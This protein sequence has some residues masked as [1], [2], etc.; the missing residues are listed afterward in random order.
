MAFFRLLFLP[1]LLLVAACGSSSSTAT[2][3]SSITRCSVTVDG[4]GSLP[5]QGGTATLAVTAARECSWSA[6]AEGTWL[7]IRSGASGQGNGS[8]EV[9]AGVNPDPVVRRGAVLLNEERVELTQAAGE[10]AITLAEGGVSFPSS[11]GAGRVEVRASSALCAWRAESN[12]SWI[13]IRSSGSGRGPGEVTFEVAPTTGGPRS[14]EIVVEGQRFAVTQADGCAYTIAPSSASVAA[15]GGGGSVTV[16]TAAGCPWTAAANVSWLSLSTREG[17][18][19]GQVTFGVD[20]TAG[21]RTGTAVIAGRT[22]TVS[23]SGAVPAPSPNPGPAP[24][25]QY[26]VE[27]RSHTVAAA[28]AAISVTV[29]TTPGCA[30]TA[31]SPASWVTL[32]SAATS[33]G[34]GTARFA[35]AATSG[36][37][38]TATVTVAGQSVTVSQ[39]QGC[40]YGISPEEASVPASGGTGRV[41]VAAGSGCSWSASSQA[42][43]LEVTSGGSG[44]GNGEVSFEAAA[45]TGEAR[46]GTLTIAGRTFTVSQEG[47]RAC[48][49]RVRPDDVRVG[50]RGD[51]VRIEVRSEAGCGWTAVSGASWIEVESG[52]SGSGDG[53]VVLDISRNTADEEREGVVTIAGERVRVRQRE[54]GDD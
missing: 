31:S 39:T 11:G 16:D 9:A 38:R 46:T 50:W 32:T 34:S 14:G 43:W 2:S 52:A 23:Q 4:G 42:S 19:P 7:S 29:T 10:C 49:Y 6:R 3:P 24:A 30:W 12:E 54:R 18:G 53:E 17:S 13:A 26:A 47:G 25:C 35:V 45:N 27:P 8:I 33:T 21:A 41:S 1:A 20:A 15:D 36:A 5:A 51:T 44:S 28:G 48:R 37:A 40:S 22:F